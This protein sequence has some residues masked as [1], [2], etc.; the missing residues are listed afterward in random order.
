MGAAF[1]QR[2]ALASQSPRTVILK[3]HEPSRRPDRTMS[4]PPGAT[5]EAASRRRSSC[6][7]GLKNWRMSRMQTFPWCSGSPLRASWWEKARSVCPRCG[8]Q[9]SGI[10]L[11]RVVVESVDGTRMPAARGKARKVRG[12]S[13][14][15]AAAG[16]SR[17]EFPPA[18]CRAGRCAASRPRSLV[19][20]PGIQAGDFPDVGVVHG[21]GGLRWS[22]GFSPRAASRGNR[23]KNPQSSRK[24]IQVSSVLSRK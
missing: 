3:R 1:I 19:P 18:R 9:A 14:D 2:V 24:C 17:G 12:R 16:P 22:R 13:R 21:I 15:L 7:S 23:R 20:G 8:S 5:R 4:F 11:P 10:D 6:S